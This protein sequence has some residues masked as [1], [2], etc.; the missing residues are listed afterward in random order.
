MS[1]VRSQ[2]NEEVTIY[3]RS[4]S[5]LFPLCFIFGGSTP[6]RSFPEEFFEANVEAGSNYGLGRGWHSRLTSAVFSSFFSLSH[7]FFHGDHEDS[8]KLDFLCSASSSFRSLLCSLIRL[9][10]TKTFSRVVLF[11]LCARRFCKKCPKICCNSFVGGTLGSNQKCCWALCGNAFF[12]CLQCVL[13]RFRVLDRHSSSP[14]WFPFSTSSFS[15]MSAVLDI[16]LR[17]W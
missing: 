8:I 15:D 6:S 1:R 3:F 11:W 7:S 5:F 14:I 16:R 4:S 12:N 2:C 17:P 9:A 13:E 10:S